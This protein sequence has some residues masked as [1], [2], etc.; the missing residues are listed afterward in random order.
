MILR[1]SNGYAILDPELVKL[2]LEN[3]AG[4]ILHAASAL[5]IDRKTLSSWL[6]RHPEVAEEADDHKQSVVDLA[7]SNVIKAVRAGDYRAS[8]FVL[9]TLGKSRGWTQRTEVTGKDGGPVATVTEPPIDV[10]KFT[11]EELVEFIRLSDKARPV[12]E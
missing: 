12:T 1:D 8:E 3:S 5:K 11:D 6:K 4:I 10:S 2:A 7:E 9:V